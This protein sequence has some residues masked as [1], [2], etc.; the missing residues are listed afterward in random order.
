MRPRSRRGILRAMLLFLLACE[1][2]TESTPATPSAGTV[3]IV[4]AAPVAGDRVAVTVT[5][6]VGTL[7]YRWTV[8]GAAAG[9]GSYLDAAVTR[10]QLVAVEVT[11]SV[12]DRADRADAATT[13]ANTP[14]TAPVVSITEADGYTCTVTTPST[15]ADGDPVTYGSVWTAPGAEI[16]GDTLSREESARGAAWTCTVTPT[17]GFD[18]GPAASASITATGP[19]PG[20]YRFEKILDLFMPGDVAPLPDGTLLVA[21][22][23]GD[24]LHVDPV[25]ADIGGPAVLGE[26]TLYEPD[27]L[28]AVVVDP[29]FGDGAHDYVYTW[30][31]HTCVLARHVITTDPFAVVRT[32]ELVTLDCP[33]EG[34]HAGGDLLFWEGDTGTPTLYLGVGPTRGSNPQ[35]ESSPGQKLLAYAIADDGTVTPGVPAPY[36]NP[37][38]LSLGLR[39]PWRL[40][41]CGSVLC[42]A[43][44][45]STL[46]EEI[47]LYTG[48]GQDFG[49]PRVEGPSDDDS[50]QPAIYWADDDDTNAIADR[51]GPGRTGFVHSPTVG[52][53]ASSAGY[54]GRLADHLVYGDIYDGWIRAV[55]IDDA[56]NLGDDVPIASLQFVLSMA[57]APD[58]TIYATPMAGGLWR[59]GYRADRPTVAA[60]GAPLS[61]AA[62]GG[63]VYDVRYPLWSNG[64]DKTRAIEIPAG[65]SIDV[66][67]EHWVFPEGT[68]VW[69][70]FS[71]DGAPVETRL[72]EKRDGEWL[73][74]TYVWDGDDAYLTDGTRQDLV[75][76][77]GEPYTVPS[78]TACV[79]CHAAT[80]GWDFV[81]GVEPFQLGDDGIAALS[82]LLSADPGP[83]PQVDTTD[84]VE[85]AVRGYLHGNCAYCHQPA[86]VVSYVSVI[87]LDLRYS[88]ADTGLLDAHAEYWHA[89]PNADDGQPLLVPGDPD[90]SALVGM[91]EDAD[92]PPLAVW[93]PD[94]DAVALLRAWIGAMPAEP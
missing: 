1:A 90:A 32:E 11:A 74:G 47:N 77:N 46:Y 80:T 29:R 28:I 13:V 86:G 55:A 56:G 84:P 71:V 61:E 79:T 14:P 51:D 8:D 67:G 19:V 22:L 6:S 23:L 87:G 58:G 48:P 78:E 72:V 83:A 66:S 50:V 17:D 4:P 75:L 64:S 33:L 76:P 20:G 38:V 3:S 88:A 34:G 24:L 53:R 21:T 85:E 45:G 94:A 59:L 2:P 65:S 68:R 27:D 92:M 43:D 62:P 16:A 31:N 93:E 37:Y 42:V 81:L 9:E 12:G 49:Y 54:A 30:T 73:V 41:D 70:T 7:A 91:I 5:G 10:G 82:G 26:A 57:E 52:V 39:N 40:A 63:V 44:P 35:S 36:E 18:D 15:D 69:K 25:G 60:V 89:N